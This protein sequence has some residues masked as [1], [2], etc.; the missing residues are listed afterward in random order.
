MKEKESETSKT[1]SG[2]GPRNR[3][4]SSTGNA[5]D[6]IGTKNLGLPSSDSGRFTLSLVWGRSHYVKFS[7]Q[8]DTVVSRIMSD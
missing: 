8:F 5:N 7:I 6:V 3:G 2:N 1:N 4:T